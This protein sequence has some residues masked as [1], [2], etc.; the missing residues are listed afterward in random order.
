MPS[1]IPIVTRFFRSL[2]TN[3]GIVFDNLDEDEIEYT[4][5]LRH[6]VGELD[7][8]HTSEAAFWF[9]T[10]GARVTDK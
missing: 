8:W 9:Q 5:R 1:V 2:Y 7:T 6:E 4:L 3:A 10:P